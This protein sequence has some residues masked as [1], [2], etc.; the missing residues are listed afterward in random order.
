[1]L[2]IIVKEKV[3]ELYNRGLNCTDVAKEVGIHRTTVSKILKRNGINV[4][5]K[6][7]NVHTNC[8]IC[9]KKITNNKGNRSRCQPCNTKVR[10]YRAKKH[11]VEYLGSEC[12]KCGWSGDISG[13]DFHHKKPEEKSFNINAVTIANR[14]WEEAKEE[15]D[16]CELLCALCHRLEH[17]DYTNEDLINEAKSYTGTIFKK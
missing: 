16:K 9:K 7:K 17:S 12:K 13:F 5:R 14:K 4:K 11:A 2:F 10:R 8:K 1:M 3:I 15:L 6:I